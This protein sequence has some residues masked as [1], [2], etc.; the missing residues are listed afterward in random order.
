MPL[1][2]RPGW[3]DFQTRKCF[4]FICATTLFFASVLLL[5]SR[6]SAGPEL[7]APQPDP[8][9]W[10]TNGAV[11]ALTPSDDEATLYVGGTFSRIGPLT[12]GGA[13]VDDIYG[14]PIGS[15]QIFQGPISA[16]VSD[17]SGG[18]LVAGWFAKVGATSCQNIV[19]LRAD[20]TVDPDWNSSIGPFTTDPQYVNGTVESLS[21]WGSILYASGSFTS[22]GGVPREN[23]AAISAASGETLDWNPG[24]NG[25]VRA[26]RRM[27]NLVY[28]GGDFTEVNRSPRR[29]LAAVDATTAVTK[30]WNPAPDS[31]VHTLDLGA[32]MVCVGGRF[33]NIAGTA[34]KSLA[35]FSHADGSLL[36]LNLD[37]SGAVYT[38]QSDGPTLYIGGDI[39]SIGG[40]ARTGLA[41]IDVDSATTGTLLPW[42]PEL[43]SAAK[44]IERVSVR[45]L[46]LSESAVFV[47]YH[48]SN[49]ASSVNP[50]VAPPMLRS[51][52]FAAFARTDAST[53][54]WQPASELFLPGSGQYPI[55]YANQRL[56]IGGPFENVGGVSASGLA[57]LDSRTGFARRWSPR[58]P[59]TVTAAAVRAIEVAGNE[60]FIGGNFEYVAGKRT[61]AIARLNTETGLPVSWTS[62]FFG[63][64]GVN[65]SSMVNDVR[66]LQLEGEALY[67]AG[68]FAV[69]NSM[70]GGPPVVE[71]Y[72]LASIAV[73][74]DPPQFNWL[75]GTGEQTAC[76]MQL[77]GDEIYIGDSRGKV[78]SYHKFT[79]Q[80]SETSYQA[81]AADASSESARIRALLATDTEL[82]VAGGFE[83]INGTTAPRLARINTADGRVAPARTDLPT[84]TVLQIASHAGKFYI[85]GDGYLLANDETTGNVVTTTNENQ[86]GLTPLSGW[87]SAIHSRQT[88]L[89]LGLYNV[90]GEQFQ[91]RSLLCFRI[92]P[93]PTPTPSPSP[94]P[95]PGSAVALRAF[96]IGE[97]GGTGGGTQPV[98]ANDDAAIDSA[99]LLSLIAGGFGAR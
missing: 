47:G 53:T 16:C 41:S 90:N 96:I 86:P 97:T 14:D 34:R 6:A 59:K 74:A 38:M 22:V 39:S 5:D 75:A 42:K 40:V 82:F 7:L 62:P 92:L 94:T 57:A 66:A 69:T 80:P 91:T 26:I 17:G 20:G 63:G 87:I 36:P 33:L 99:D 93:T 61:A 15:P 68:R 56:F 89:Y 50:S 98:D 52:S 13:I 35:A 70:S 81:L 48:G 27:G 21:L 58:I 83:S 64:D 77:I 19:H 29:Y 88:G 71:Y 28:L 54:T 18:W 95:A 67:A 60:L 25:R 37:I 43:W 11:L 76:T 32:G 10:T 55:A 1:I 9:A 65:Y 24:A 3:I 31:V 46:A 85:G 45:S 51:N 12:G 72:N 79:G 23:V 8:A 44:S 84:S 49:F 78:S 30:S 73:N 4:C 2:L